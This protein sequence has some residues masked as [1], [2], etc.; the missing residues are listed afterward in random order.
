ME[1]RLYRIVR[2]VRMRYL[3]AENNTPRILRFPFILDASGRVLSSFEDRNIGVIVFQS[4]SE[5][6]AAV[7]SSGR[8]CLEN[9]CFHG[10]VYLWD[11]RR[12]LGRV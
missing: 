11:I 7:R 6:G 9:L 12:R 1:G 8:V 3:C 2:I 10:K 4:V 5:H